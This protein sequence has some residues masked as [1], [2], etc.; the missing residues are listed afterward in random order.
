[1]S[2][3]ETGKSLQVHRDTV[4]ELGAPKSISL[5][6]AGG[7]LRAP[8]NWGQILKVQ[9]IQAFFS[10]AQKHRASAPPLLTLREAQASSS[11]WCDVPCAP[12]QTDANVKPC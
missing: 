1:M 11:L 12:A 2:D 10:L 4:T 8:G 3:P 7:P 5:S 9:P 6:G